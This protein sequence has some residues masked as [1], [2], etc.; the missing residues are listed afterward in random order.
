VLTGFLPAYSYVLDDGIQKLLAWGTLIFFIWVPV[1]AIVTWIIRRI[2]GKRGSSGII[3]LTFLSLWI[4]G[5]ICFVNLLVSVV[6]DF[7]YR[8]SPNE[9]TVALPNPGVSKLEIKTSSMRKYYNNDWL[10]FEPFNSY[11]DDTVYL[12]NVRLRITKSPTDSFQVILVKM[13]NGDSKAQAGRL[14]SRINFN[15]L[16]KDSVLS[17][18]KGIAITR[19]DKFRNQQ[20]IVT[21][22]VPVGKRIY[23]NDNVSWDNDVRLPFGRDNNSWDWENSMESESLKWRHNIEYI[24]TENGLERVNKQHNEDEDE[25]DNSNEAIEDFRKSREQIEREKEQKIKELEEIDRELQ[26]ATDSTRYR[27]KPNATDST[28][29]PKREDRKVKPRRDNITDAGFPTGINDM[30]MIKFSL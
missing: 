27:Y 25:E 6:S 3:R 17:L 18:D 9:E 7:R 26:K 13:A 16:Q 15:I 4:L 19:Q 21:V 10:E 29:V 23:I 14:A 22:A 20:V 8:N 12:R 24:M 28:N 2:T 5:L 30:L 11:Q 1:I